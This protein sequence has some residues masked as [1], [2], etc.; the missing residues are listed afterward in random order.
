LVFAFYARKN[1]LAPNLVA[2]AGVAI[3]LVVA[4]V[5]VRPF[6]MMGLVFANSAQ[7]TGHALVM[8]WL[9]RSRL[10][11]LGESGMA[12]TLVKIS[13]ASVLMGVAVFIAQGMGGPNWWRVVMPI[14]AGAVVYVGL[15][16]IL[17]VQE[18]ER[19]LHTVRARVRR[20]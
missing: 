6:G 16:R 5:L 13:I 17:H 12:T 19:L 14:T 9:A 4:L 20:V 8:I 3:Y 1:T 11:G 7:L 10:G 2:F 15:L 18:A